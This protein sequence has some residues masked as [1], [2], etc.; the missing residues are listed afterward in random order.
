MYIT[1][2]STQDEYLKKYMKIY[3]PL[4]CMYLKMKYKQFIFQ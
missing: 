2:V 1:G 3:I 4:I